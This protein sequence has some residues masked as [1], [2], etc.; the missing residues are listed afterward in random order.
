MGSQ[1]VLLLVGFLLTTVLGGLLGAWL[2][3]RAWRNQRD[4]QR[5]DEER[6]QAFR[7]FEELSSLLDRRIYRMR[8]LQSAAREAAKD[9]GETPRLDSA[10]VSYRETLLV[11]NDN[12]NRL[13]ALVQTYF[14]DE[15]RYRLEHEINER[16]SSIGRAIEECV[17]RARRQDYQPTDV[18]AVRRRVDALAHRVYNLNVSM[19]KLLQESKIGD[20]AP[21][22]ARP[23][24]ESN[25]MLAFGDVG[26]AVRRLQEL[27][28]SAGARDL[29]VDGGFGR[30]TALAV[31]DFQSAH[32]LH[33]DGTV[34]DETWSV[35]RADSSAD[36]AAS[37]KG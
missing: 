1:L 23:A 6:Q 11:W 5:H 27:L 28:R 16:F 22:F 12:L 32:G 33:V 36:D 34:G 30:D 26:E 31:R 29:F 21:P 9:A 7:A 15:I 18:A 4:V 35:L 2:Q 8:L 13:Q 19:L 37:A 24:P 14:G 10:L 20:A 25:P 3:G 17:R